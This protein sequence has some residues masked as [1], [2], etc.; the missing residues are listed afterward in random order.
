MKSVKKRER[1]SA[2]TTT[3]I[4]KTTLRRLLLHQSL[5]LHFWGYQVL[6]DL[7]VA[8]DR[9]YHR[10]ECH[11]SGQYGEDGGVADEAAAI[12]FGAEAR[13]LVATDRSSVKFPLP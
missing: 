3:T 12:I 5:P 6:V 10:E 1:S 9:N 7:L 8:E 13:V 4:R 2:T 11:N